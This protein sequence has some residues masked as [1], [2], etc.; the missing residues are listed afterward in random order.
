M[1]E[2]GMEFKI[3]NGVLKKYTGNEKNVIIP[4]GVKR[5]GKEAFERCENLESVTIP[6]GVKSIGDYAFNGCS[7]LSSVVI[8]DS[9]KN[10]GE[11]VFRNCKKNLNLITSENSKC[12][13]F[14][15]GILYDAKKKKIYLVLGGYSKRIKFNGSVSM[16]IFDREGFIEANNADFISMEILNENEE[17]LKTLLYKNLD[18]M[19][20]LTYTPFL[21][22]RL[23]TN[24]TINQINNFYDF[25]IKF[26]NAFDES[27]VNEIYA[28]L[29]NQKNVDINNLN[30]II[31]IKKDN[32]TPE[33]YVSNHP[34]EQLIK[35]KYS[36]EM[37]N[38][39]KLIMPY[40]Y[41]IELKYKDTGEELSRNAITY[42]FGSYIQI[43]ER[44]DYTIDYKTY[45]I[46]VHIDDI[47][48]KISVNVDMNEI[49]EEFEKRCDQYN[50]LMFPVYCR[51]AN[52][53]Q[54][55]DIIA[56]I[57]E[58]SDWYSYGNLGRQAV[59][60]ARSSLMLNDTNEAITYFQKNKMLD[61]YAI[62]H[63]TSVDSLENNRIYNFGFD[64]NGKLEFN[65]GSK[66]VTATL[67]KDFSIL[68]FDNEA[69][70]IVKSIPKRNADKTLYNEV[71]T[72]F[73]E[74]K[75]NLKNSVKA[76]NNELFDAFLN[77]SEYSVEEW[78]EAYMNNPVLHI[79]AELIV[80]SQGNKTF[81]LDENKAIDSFGKKYNID[82]NKKI[83]VAHPIEMSDDDISKWQK[84]FT[85]NKLKQPFA[86][87]W[88]PKFNPNNI[89]PD[90][91]TGCIIPYYR[92]RNME[93]HGITVNNNIYVDSS[94]EII[95]RDCKA[96]VDRIDFRRHELRNDD[97]FEVESFGFD[98]FTRYT[99]HI[100]TY[101]D[102]ITVLDKILKDDITVVGCIASFTVAQLCEFISTAVENKCVKVV[103]ALLNYKNEHFG[104]KDVMDG[105]T[106]DWI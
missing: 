1:E 103:D 7:K 57:K 42:L 68:L 17:W 34:C 41:N 100:I 94:V 5:I 25:Y 52:E 87:I 71:S 85:D 95:F 51:F 77:G 59:I 102:K 23:K 82:G 8:P 105:Y 78:I 31:R 44:P 73:S 47:A 50:M 11:H 66:T 2:D 32:K 101:L 93:K 76:K 53:R 22:D 72:K 99:N 37:E 48:D 86:Q 21:I 63:N 29:A 65:L 24:L 98:K 56:K 18:K 43:A 14:E 35:D 6:N 55:K 97:R 4:D 70:K 13:L 33:N 91:Y 3:V 19:K 74:I 46:K 64:V 36:A 89:K 28:L 39:V 20:K 80:W 9:I 83:K 96:K 27:T 54:V 38:R 49:M 81:L 79:V 16:N 60:V 84:Y 75:K 61:R 30:K 69:N 88:E 45:T 40:V 104:I 67:N 92:F 26:G 62:A 15:K 10:I 58:W 106:L 90:R 12:Y